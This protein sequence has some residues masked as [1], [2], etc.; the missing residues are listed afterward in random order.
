MA[1]GGAFHTSCFTC[2][3][4]HKQLEITTVY[5]SQGEIYCKGM[6]LFYKCEIG[7]QGRYLLLQVATLNILGFWDMDLVQLCSPF[8]SN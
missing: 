5:E 1:A 7:K 4:C 3:C 8:N 6:F 2:Y